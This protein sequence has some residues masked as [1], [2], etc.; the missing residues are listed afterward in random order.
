MV[1]YRILMTVSGGPGSMSLIHAL[2][3]HPFKNFTLFAGRVDGA[4]NGSLLAVDSFIDIPYASDDLYE[5]KMLDICTNNRIELVISGYTDEVLKLSKARAEFEAKG[6]RILAPNYK[7]VAICRDKAL[8]N[9]AVCNLAPEYLIPFS[10]IFSVSELLTACGEMGYPDKKLCVKPSVCNGGS[11]GFWILDENYDRHHAF[12]TE[13]ETK[14]CTPSELVLKL[15]GIR[16]LPSLLLMPFIDGVVY[17]VDVLARDGQVI[18][19]V[20][21]EC[22]NPVLAGMNMRM[23]ICEKEAISTMIKKLTQLFHL[24]SIFNVDVIM[25]DGKPYLIEINPRQSAFI[26]LTAEK[27]NLLAMSIDMC[28]GDLKDIGVYTV[29]QEYQNIMA[30][31][32]IEEFAICNGT[33]VQYQKKIY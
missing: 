8:L 3:R 2:R 1:D 23:A 24:D 15:E 6:V 17:G 13:K 18:S 5:E 32:Y 7:A 25:D 16:L 22:M 27:I 12:F 31:R 11:R 33:V 20:I 28:M 26:G 19:H 30:I 4:E 9:K 21:R 14:Y 29:K 10:E